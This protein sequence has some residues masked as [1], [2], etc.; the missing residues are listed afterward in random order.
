VQILVVP[1]RNAEAAVI[2]S[3]HC[4]PL[5]EG[6]GLARSP[7]TAQNPAAALRADG[8]GASFVSECAV[9]RGT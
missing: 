3:V 7:S 2:N 4:G 1:G 5:V 6:S 8:E 9:A